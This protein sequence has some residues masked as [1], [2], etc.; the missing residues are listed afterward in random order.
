MRLAPYLAA[1]VALAA[2]CQRR[3]PGPEECQS[4]AAAALGLNDAR[5]LE[6][7]GV[8]ESFDQL[9]VHCLT[10]PFDRALVRCVEERS[11]PGLIVE[12]QRLLLT[13]GAR[14]CLAE[15]ARRRAELEPAASNEP[16]RLPWLDRG[17]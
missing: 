10:T 8:K 13:P 17:P 14:S 11:A 4:F 2:A 1:A 5:M 6:T 16:Q 12:R 7:P 15:F 9:V 3:A